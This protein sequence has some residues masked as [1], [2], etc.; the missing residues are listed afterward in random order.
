M[1]IKQRNG[2]FDV[3][4]TKVIAGQIVEKRVRGLP[5]KGEARRVEIILDNELQQL[6]LKGWPKTVLWKD[7]LVDFYVF[8]QKKFAYSTFESAKSI[9]NR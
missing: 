2:K 9:L 3:R 4:L 6:K 5:T 8:A 1:A 7:A